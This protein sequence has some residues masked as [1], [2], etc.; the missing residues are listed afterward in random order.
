MKNE[1]GMAGSKSTQTRDIA[2]TIHPY[3]CFSRLLAMHLYINFNNVNVFVECGI[4]ETF[5]LFPI[6]YLVVTMVWV[7]QFWFNRIITGYFCIPQKA[8]V[9]MYSS[10]DISCLCTFWSCHPY[11]ILQFYSIVF[12]LVIASLKDLN[13][14]GRVLA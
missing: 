13:S 1:V 4:W 5:R 14:H 7:Y 6:I 3:A 12:I 9:G 11:F 2:T 10:C 8:S